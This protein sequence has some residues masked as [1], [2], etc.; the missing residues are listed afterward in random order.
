MLACQAAGDQTG[1]F[2]VLSHTMQE[3]CPCSTLS[4]S[5]GLLTRSSSICRA[6]SLINSRKARPPCTGARPGGLLARRLAQQPLRRH[7]TPCNAR[8]RGSQPAPPPDEDLQDE[9]ALIAEGAALQDPDSAEALG[10]P[11]RYFL[12]PGLILALRQARAYARCQSGISS[13]RQ[14]ARFRDTL[15]VTT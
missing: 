14:R 6:V 5:S 8:R 12:L 2:R 1:H 3:F 10:E 7:C 9:E 11:E 13:L 15:P 4:Q